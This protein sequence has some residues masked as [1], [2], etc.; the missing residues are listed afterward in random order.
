VNRPRPNRASPNRSGPNRASPNSCDPN[1]VRPNRLRRPGAAVAV[2]VALAALLSGCGIRDTAL[3]VDAGEGASRTAC[4]PA[5]GVSLSQLDRD[6]YASPAT[7]RTARPRDAVLSPSASPSA[8]PVPSPA[9]TCL[10]T[11]APVRAPASRAPA[12][13]PSP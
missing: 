6:A 3:P 4:P 8:A 5:P 1:R 9:A 2:V 11:G 10:R 7:D 12:T 13:S